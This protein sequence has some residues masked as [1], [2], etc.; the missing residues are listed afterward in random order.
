M[1]DL[2]LCIVYLDSWLVE[3][4][5]LYILLWVPSWTCVTVATWIHPHHVHVLCA[6]GAW[7]CVS[8]ATSCRLWRDRYNLQGAG[9][10][11]LQVVSEPR[12]CRYPRVQ[13]AYRITLP[14]DVVVSSVKTIL[15]KMRWIDLSSSAFFSLPSMLLC[16]YLCEFCVLS[17]IRFFEFRFLR[18][19]TISCLYPNR[20]VLRKFIVVNTSKNHLLVVSRRNLLLVVSRSSTWSAKIW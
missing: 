19:W 1:Y 4:S 3:S 10:G 16:S 7:W 6:R 20:I 18:G 9:F 2:D 13:F 12:F 8:K 15:L 14:T 11:A 5:W 17:L